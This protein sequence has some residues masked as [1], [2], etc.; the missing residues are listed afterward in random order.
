MNALFLKTPAFARVFSVAD[1]WVRA[2]FF[3]GARTASVSFASVH[4]Y[5]RNLLSPF[6]FH[7]FGVAHQ[8]SLRSPLSLSGATHEIWSRSFFR[9]LADTETLAW[10]DCSCNAYAR[11][12]KNDMNLVHSA[13]VG[14]RNICRTGEQLAVQFD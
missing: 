4:L 1:H 11:S 5:H 10:E 6:L 8:A 12:A 7:P 3:V 14:K 2:H 13:V 9:V